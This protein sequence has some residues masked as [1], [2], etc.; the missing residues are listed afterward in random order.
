M[1]WMEAVSQLSLKSIQ[2]WFLGFYKSINDDLFITNMYLDSLNLRKLQN[3]ILGQKHIY[4]LMTLI[5]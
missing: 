3:N 1:T 5:G 4:Y 2:W